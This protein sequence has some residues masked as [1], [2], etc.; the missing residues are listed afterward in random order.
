MGD[1]VIYI[2]DDDP[3]FRLIA[4]KLIEKSGKFSKLEFF[5]NG[6]DALIAVKNAIANSTPPNA[7]M[8][9]IEMPKMNGWQFMENFTILPDDKVKGINIYIVSSSIALEDRNKAKSYSSIKLYIAKPI[10]VDIINELGAEEKS[11]A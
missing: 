2:I 10:T 3:V 7:I 6:Y 9:D 5:E 4:R 1:K 11:H 8:L